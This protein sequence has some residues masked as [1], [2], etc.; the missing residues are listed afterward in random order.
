M[1]MLASMQNEM[2]GALQAGRQASIAPTPELRMTDSQRAALMDKISQR[3]GQRQPLSMDDLPPELAK[4]ITEKSQDFEA[5]FISSMLRPM[6]EGISTDAP[7]GGGHA[8]AMWRDMLIDEYGKTISKAG[9][10][11]LAD[12]VQR[13]LL[14]TQEAMSHGTQ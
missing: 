5:F 14:R 1:D 10:I 3:N 4:Q 12:Q 9:G 8:E 13:E 6:F 11:G 7:F 2:M